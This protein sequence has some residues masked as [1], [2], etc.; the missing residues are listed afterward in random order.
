VKDVP[1]RRPK[2]RERLDQEALD[3]LEPFVEGL[4]FEMTKIAAK[5]PNKP[6]SDLATKQV[7]RAITDAKKLVGSR[8]PYLASLDLFVPAGQNP[9]PHDAVI[10]LRQIR[11]TL[12][13]VT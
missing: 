1:P 10:V 5:T 2:A 7:N 3:A 4:Y 8:D 11:E 9:E 12:Q 6:I 13:R